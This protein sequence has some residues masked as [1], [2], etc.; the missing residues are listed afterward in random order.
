MSQALPSVAPLQRGVIPVSTLFPACADPAWDIGDEQHSHIDAVRREL[1]DLSGFSAS[2]DLALVQQRLGALVSRV[3]AM[4]EIANSGVYQMD[5]G[6]HVVTKNDDAN[7]A[8]GVSAA[9]RIIGIIH[10]LNDNFEIFDLL[11][12]SDITA[13]LRRAEIGL[14]AIQHNHYSAQENF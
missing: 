8:L 12:R 2:C 11:Q 6:R 10:E 7:Y 3:V 14:A 4:L 13:F 1:R 9:F 5:E